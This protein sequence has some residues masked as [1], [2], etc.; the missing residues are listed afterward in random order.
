MQIYVNYHNRIEKLPTENPSIG[1]LLC[2]N[3]NAGAVKFTLPK[4]SKNISASHYKLYR[5]TEQQL[6]EEGNK[7]LEK[8]E[9]EK[10]QGG[11]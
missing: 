10:E 5:P 8:I 3:K 9:E 1:I 4:N 6:L 2:A 7:E 11:I